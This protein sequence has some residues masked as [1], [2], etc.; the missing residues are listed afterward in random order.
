VSVHTEKTYTCDWVAEDEKVCG[1]TSDAVSTDKEIYDLG[2]TKL[3]VQRYLGYQAKWF[4]PRHS[5]VFKANSGRAPTSD[6]YGKP[7]PPRKRKRRWMQ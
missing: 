4:C 1:E 3:D 5:T 7:I 2:W 6:L